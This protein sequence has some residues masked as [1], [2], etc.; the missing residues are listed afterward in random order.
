LKLNLSKLS[1]QNQTEAIYKAAAFLGKTLSEEQVQNLKDHLSFNKMK[2]NSAV[3]LE[4]VIEKAPKVDKKNN[5][6]LKFIRKGQVM[7]SFQLYMY[8]VP[9]IIKQQNLACQRQTKT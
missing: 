4:A 7:K 2:E 3:N 9:S 6:D 1:F 8:W 5:E